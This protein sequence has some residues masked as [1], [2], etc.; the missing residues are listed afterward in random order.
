MPDNSKL[1]ATDREFQMES[2]KEGVSRA[3]KNIEIF[4]QE[5]EKQRTLKAQLQ[6]ELEK[7]MSEKWKS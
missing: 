4:S 3:E 5:V 2:L 1:K 6:A 7:L